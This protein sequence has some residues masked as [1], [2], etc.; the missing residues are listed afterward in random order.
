MIAFKTNWLLQWRTTSCHNDCPKCILG[1][2]TNTRWAPEVLRPRSGIVWV[3]F[4]FAFRPCRQFLNSFEVFSVRL[5]V[6]C[7]PIY[8]L[9]TILVFTFV[10]LFSVVFCC[11]LVLLFYYFAYFLYYCYLYYNFFTIKLCLFF[12]LIFGFVN[13]L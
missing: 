9:L 10:V 7:F 3:S 13:W 4:L 1:P 8:K 5:H 6:F 11:I 2:F 12:M